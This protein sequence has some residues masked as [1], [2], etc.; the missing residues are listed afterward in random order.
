M[1][2]LQKPEVDHHIIKTSEISDRDLRV[3]NLSLRAHSEAPVCLAEEEKATSDIL[4]VQLIEAPVC[5]A[6]EEKT[7]SDILAVQLIEAPVCLAEE[8]KATSD[9]LA[10][11]LIEA[12]VCLAE[13]EKATSDILAVQ[14]IEAL[15]CL[16]EEEKTTSD[17]LAVQLIEAPVCLA[18]EEKATSDILAVQLTTQKRVTIVIFACL[19]IFLIFLTRLFPSGFYLY[20]VQKSGFR[21]I[22]GKIKDVSILFFIINNYQFSKFKL[23]NIGW[24][25][26]Y[27]LPN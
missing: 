1:V 24:Y 9:I 27:S 19:G 13:E 4:A 18:E 5:L 14:L 3:I 17:I 22:I 26:F 6:E 25:R 7:T 12:P 21:T 11:Q 8:E 15:V 23:L 2:E 16:A 20:F 10:V